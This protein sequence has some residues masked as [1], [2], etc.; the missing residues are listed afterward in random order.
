MFDHREKDP[1]LEACGDA[2]LWV[3]FVNDYCTQKVYDIG[4]RNLLEEE[5]DESN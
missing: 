2:L 5:E 3:L 4:S 1:E